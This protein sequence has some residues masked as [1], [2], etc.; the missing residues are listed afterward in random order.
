MVTLYKQITLDIR[1]NFS[2]GSRY[3]RA[4]IRKILKRIYNKYRINRTPKH[5]DLKD[6]LIIKEIK[7]MGERMVDVIG[8]RLE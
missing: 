7:V 5:Y 4:E 6:A 3:T 2:T 8:K 1:C